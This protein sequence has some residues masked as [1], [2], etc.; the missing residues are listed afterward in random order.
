MENEIRLS[1]RL[2]FFVRKYK[3]EEVVKG[4]ISDE[5]YQK[6]MTSQLVGL[7]REKFN[8]RS[9]NRKKDVGNESGFYYS[10]EKIYK[11]ISISILC[12]LS[13]YLSIFGQ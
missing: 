1:D 9:K 4:K 11:Y 13:M 6:V 3:L 8:S 12:E 10:I 5:K 2:M 7:I